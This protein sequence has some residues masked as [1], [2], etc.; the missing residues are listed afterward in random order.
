MLKKHLPNMLICNMPDTHLENMILLVCRQIQAIRQNISDNSHQSP[1]DQYLNLLHGGKSFDIEEA[2]DRNTDKIKL[3]TPYLA[4]AFVRGMS[5]IHKDVTEA[6]GRSTAVNISTEA[7]DDVVLQIESGRI[8]ALPQ[9]G[10]N[11]TK[12]LNDD[13]F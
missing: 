4:E 8:V 10:K 5:H 2:V 12:A 1:D 7:F 11:F 3:L 6:L 13:N 9:G